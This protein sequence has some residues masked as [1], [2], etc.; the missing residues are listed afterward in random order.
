MAVDQESDQPIPVTVA[1]ASQGGKQPRHLV[2]G[3]VLADTI[4]GVRLAPAR[5]DWSHFSAFHQLEARRFHWRSFAFDGVTGHNM[6]FNATRRQLTTPKSEK[7][8]R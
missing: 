2:L 4:G 7:R 6:P 3:Q 5:S 1:V 8:A